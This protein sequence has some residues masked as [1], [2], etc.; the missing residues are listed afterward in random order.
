MRTALLLVVLLIVVFTRRWRTHVDSSLIVRTLDPRSDRIHDPRSS[1]DTD[2]C[3]VEPSW[4]QQS[5]LRHILCARTSS[6][7]RVVEGRIL[8]QVWWYVGCRHIRSWSCC[9]VI[10]VTTTNDEAK[11]KNVPAAFKRL[12]IYR[13]TYVFYQRTRTRFNVEYWTM[14]IRSHFGLWSV[15]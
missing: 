5:L 1:P 8:R 14:N 6:I 3:M 12:Q 10:T 9:Q 11:I 7:V 4:H 13:S 15:M 2:T